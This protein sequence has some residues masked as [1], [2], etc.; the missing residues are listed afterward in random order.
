ME[1][2]LQK[3]KYSLPGQPLATYIHCIFVTST[4]FRTTVPAFITH[5]V[6]ANYSH[7]Q[8]A[9]IQIIEHPSV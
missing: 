3:K 7:R 8:T 5:E 2:L 1:C 6:E 4:R 9:D